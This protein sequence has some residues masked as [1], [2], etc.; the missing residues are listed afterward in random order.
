PAG[1][2]TLPLHDALPIYR[3]LSPAPHLE[4]DRRVRRSGR[5]RPPAAGR[6]ARVKAVLTG[7]RGFGPDVEAEIVLSRDSFSIRYDMDRETGDRKSTRLNS[8]HGSNT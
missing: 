3:R 7:P 2:P 5:D 4:N 6:T 1:F 8:S